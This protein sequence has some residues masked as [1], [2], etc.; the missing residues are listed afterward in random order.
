MNLCVRQK[1][2]QEH[3]ERLAVARGRGLGEGRRGRSGSADGCSCR[4]WLNSQ[5]LPYRTEN[6]SQ[7]PVINHHG[8]EYFKKGY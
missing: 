4:E 6:Y 1:W 2:T 3:R 7:Y 5:V 8:K